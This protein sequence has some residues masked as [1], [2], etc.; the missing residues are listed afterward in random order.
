MTTGIDSRPSRIF[1]FLFFTLFL[2]S[3]SIA[4]FLSA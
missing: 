2:V 1:P 4:T 3:V